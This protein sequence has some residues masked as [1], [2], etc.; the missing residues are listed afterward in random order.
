MSAHERDAVTLYSGLARTAPQWH[1][2]V[3]E[4]VA[5]VMYD[6]ADPATGKVG[7]CWTD[8][9]GKWLQAPKG[10]DPVILEYW[11]P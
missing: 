11:R 1:W 7:Q 6:W 8:E 10:Q 3:T 4:I 2:P 5:G 9:G